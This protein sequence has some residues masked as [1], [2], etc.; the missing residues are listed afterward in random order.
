MALAEE[1]EAAAPAAEALAE[2]MA[3]AVLVVAEEAEEAAAA[4]QA[5]DAV[6]SE[7][8]EPHSPA[9]LTEMPHAEP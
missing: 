8:A 9:V 3:L 7:K 1:A 4:R 6:L 5:P 2:E